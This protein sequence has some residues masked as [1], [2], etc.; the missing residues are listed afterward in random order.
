[1]IGRGVF[2]KWTVKYF[3]DKSDHPD[4]LDATFAAGHEIDWPV[5]TNQIASVKEDKLD[6]KWGEKPPVEG[7]KN[8]YWSAR[9]TGIIFVPKDDDYTF[10]F[11]ELDDAGRL[12][13]DGKELFKVWKVQKSTPSNVEPVK[14]K[15]GEHKI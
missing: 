7:M 6:F 15:R 9:M 10:F 1:L 5:F 14:L 11:D 8:T 12:V 4:T 3:Q 2:G 13:L